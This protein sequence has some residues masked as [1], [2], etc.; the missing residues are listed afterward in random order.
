MPFRL[1]DVKKTVRSRSDGH[2]YIHPKLLQG[3]AVEAQVGL[4]LAYLHSRLGRARKE[5]DPE[6][7]VRFFGDPKVARGLMACL[8]ASYRWRTQEFAEVLT[9]SEL[10]RLLRR[11]L[12]TSCDLRLYLFDRLNRASAGFLDAPRPEHLA[13]LASTLGLEAAKLDQL[14]A[15]DADENAVLIRHGAPPQPRQVVALY[16]YQV[17]D[18]LLRNSVAIHLDGV[19]AATH[20]ALEHACKAHGVRLDVACGTA[21]LHNE[22]DVFGSYARGGARVARALYTVCATDPK[23]LTAGYA[24]VALPGKQA[25]YELSRETLKA[26]TAER[27][28]IRCAPPWSALRIAWDRQ[29]ATQGVDG[30]RLEAWPEPALSAAGLALAPFAAR[31]GDHRVLVWPVEARE[32]LDDARALRAVAV[33]VLPLLAGALPAADD[34]ARPLALQS[35]GVAAIV[36]MLSAHW[37]DGR[38]PAGVQALDGLLA[39]LESVGFIAEGR[40]MD[41]LA[42]ASPRELATR[43]RFLDTTQATYVAGLGLCSAAFAAGMRKGLRRRTR[44]K[45]AA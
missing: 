42:C 9:A 5:V 35:D 4:A 3:P 38:V 22:P 43:L 33:A 24:T 1:A 19:T 18:A 32:G 41:A 21:V 17:T 7:L 20:T 45:T 23:A 6:T 15:L 8:S 26:L 29:R 31:R 25:R 44:N 12:A 30:W 27:G 10:A 13:A 16:N 14:V 37:G 11:R 28:I 2:R 36:A 40:V 34:G 39:E